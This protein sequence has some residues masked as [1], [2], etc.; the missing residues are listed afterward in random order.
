MEFLDSTKNFYSGTSGLTPVSLKS[1]EG[2]GYD[3]CHKI[4]GYDAQK[5]HEDCKQLEKSDFANRCREDGGLFKCCIR[6]DKEFCHECRFC[7]TLSVCTTSKGTRY[8]MTEK[9]LKNLR[10]SVVDAGT[11]NAVSGFSLDIPMIY[12]F[13]YRCLKPKNGIPSEQWPHYEMDGFRAAK[14][15]EDLENVLEI[16]FDKYFF[17]FEDPEVLN[18]MTNGKDSGLEMWKKT[19]GF[20]WAAW[21]PGNGMQVDRYKRNKH[22]LEAEYG[23]F[24]QERSPDSLF[25]RKR[26]SVQL[27]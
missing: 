20:D 5:C 24:A 21:V 23:S 18:T 12:F 9:S 25:F 4:V 6:R 14:T 13:D 16:P 3:T 26:L 15:E 10:A 17:N 7:C 27:F 22:C 2:L 19:Y 11:P 8:R 1:W